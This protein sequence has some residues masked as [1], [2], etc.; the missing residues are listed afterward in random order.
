MNPTV[1]SP[2]VM[3]LTSQITAGGP[4]CTTALNC[5]EPPA[6]TVAFA[7]ETAIWGPGSGLM[8][9]VAEADFVASACNTAVIVTVSAPETFAGAV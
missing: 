3:P 4:F 2:T 9:T 8:V 1:E 5:S 6:T 7:G